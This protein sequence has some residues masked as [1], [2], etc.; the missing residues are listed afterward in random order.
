MFYDGDLQS[1][2]AKAVQE[3]KLVLCFVTGTYLPNDNMHSIRFAD[4]NSDENEESQLWENEFLQQE[5]VSRPCCIRP[6]FDIVQDQVET[7]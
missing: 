6:V 3:S 1:G 4:T 2:I 5:E 7:T